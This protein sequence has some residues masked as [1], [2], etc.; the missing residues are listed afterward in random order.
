MDLVKASFT[1]KDFDVDVPFGMI[2]T[3]FTH[4]GKGFVHCG[5]SCQGQSNLKHF[6]EQDKRGWIDD[7]S[8]KAKQNNQNLLA[9]KQG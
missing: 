6:E 4:F 5:W 8:Q 1:F 9:A 7:V 3:K 2:V